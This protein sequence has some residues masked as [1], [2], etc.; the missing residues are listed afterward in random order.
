MSVNTFNYI[1]QTLGKQLGFEGAETGRITPHGNHARAFVRNR[2]HNLRKYF[3]NALESAG[4]PRNIIE[5]WMGHTPTVIETAYY[6][7]KDFDKLKEIYVRHMPLLSFE[8]TPI[9]RSLDTED[10]RKLADLEVENQKLKLEMQ[11]TK[12]LKARLDKRDLEVEEMKR[13][14]DFITATLAV[15]KAQ[16]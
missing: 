9:I 7:N 10:A 11:G 4:V 6:E 1:F 16:N 5:Y 12:E 3:S 14:L 15:K 2:S 8:T 13:Q